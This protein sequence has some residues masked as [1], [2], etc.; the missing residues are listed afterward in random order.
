M[1][2]RTYLL[3]YNLSQFA[4]WF[5]IGFL[6]WPHLLRL[7]K[8]Q[9]QSSSVAAYHDCCAILRLFL[10]APYLEVVHNLTGLVK[11]NAVLTFCQV[12][13]RAIYAL[14]ITDNFAIARYY[15]MNI[16]LISNAKSNGQ[17]LHFQRTSCLCF[18]ADSLVAKWSHP[19]PFLCPEHHR[20]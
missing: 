12:S 7:V 8:S 4:G 3:A 9:G 17:N 18:V 11:G 10:L 16:R 2:K 13:G 15:H 14:I 20:P 19:L 6:I 5:Y 1:F